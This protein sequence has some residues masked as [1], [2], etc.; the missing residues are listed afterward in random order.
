MPDSTLGATGAGEEALR[1]EIARQKKMIR[2]L[3]NR[4]ERSTNAQGSDFD[5]F[6]TTIM[7]GD[8]VRHRTAELEAALHDNEEI[9]R[10][11]Q[12]AQ[13]ELVTTARRAGMAEIAK[14][15]L[16]N[17]GNV[18]NSVT[19]SAGLVSIRMR[20]SKA[21]ALAQA[22]GLL[23]EHAAD[24]G[25]F[26]TRDAKGRMLPRYMDTLVAALAAE[27][28]SIIIELVSLTKS[29]AHIKDILATQRSYAGAA[30]VVEAVQIRDLLEEALRISAAALAHHQVTVVRE[31]AEAPM[32]L[33]DAHLL[34]QIL[35]NLIG[36]AAQ[37]MVD[38]CDR[39]P[40]ITVRL[41]VTELEAGHRLRI[42]V[43]DYGEGISAENLPRLFS[44]GFTT[45]KNGHGFGLHSCALGAK[46][47]GGTL[48]A[49]SDGPG[50]G[51]IFTLELPVKST[52]SL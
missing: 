42:R 48:T 12:G 51:A 34:L 6:Q 41:E 8:Q 52:A 26:L 31:F 3:M 49:H 17:I 33:L 9:T 1:A 13:S 4:A 5:L 19:V 11:L 22:V 27:Q 44:H 2:A 21:H 40:Q 46:E 30:N 10:E 24:L 50:T 23:S 39:A 14:N 28:Q 45:R 37:A 32:L 29:I 7:L 16:H 38:V 47:M 25:D 15:M 35:V 43:E 36:N 18:L 20:D